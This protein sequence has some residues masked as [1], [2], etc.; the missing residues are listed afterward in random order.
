MTEP[1]QSE[2]LSSFGIV[3]RR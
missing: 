2:P 3:L 1:K